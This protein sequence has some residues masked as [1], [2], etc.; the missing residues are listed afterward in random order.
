MKNA[1]IM[2]IGETLQKIS[3]HKIKATRHRVIDIGIERYSSP[4]FLE[5]KHSARIGDGILD[6]SRK[7][8][9]DFEYDQDPANAEEVEKLQPFGRL[10][11][12]KITGAYGEWKGFKIPEINYDYEEMYK[13]QK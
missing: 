11:T 3:G 6:S 2:N 9:E 10:V 5:P 4:F 7:Q 13:L 12:A 1:I 8:S